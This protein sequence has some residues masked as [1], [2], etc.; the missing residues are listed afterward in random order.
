[1]ALTLPGNPALI[2]IFYNFFYFFLCPAGTSAG[3]FSLSKCTTVAVFA[4]LTSDLRV[5]AGGTCV[6][7]PTDLFCSVPG[8]LSLLSSTSKYKVTIA[9]VKRRLSP[10]ECL[11]ASLLG[12]ILRRSVQN[13]AAKVC[14]SKTSEKTEPKW[15]KYLNLTVLILPQRAEV[16]K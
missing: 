14:V 16:D 2:L 6:V 8:R 5:F 3:S 4:P 11:N 1:M 12:G 7:N 9:E 10:P 13:P 15:S